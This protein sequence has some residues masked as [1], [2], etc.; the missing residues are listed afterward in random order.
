[1]V[2]DNTPIQRLH[3]TR[4]LSSI[5]TYLHVTTFTLIA[6]CELPC[7]LKFIMSYGWYMLFSRSIVV[8]YAMQYAYTVWLYTEYL[9]LKIM[10][11]RCRY[12]REMLSG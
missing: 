12:V 10:F 3:T 11:Y 4:V 6:K 7:A 8:A 1:M 9:N 2:L 5:S